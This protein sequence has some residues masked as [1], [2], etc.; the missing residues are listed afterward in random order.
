VI[1]CFLVNRVNIPKLLAH[2]FAAAQA[3]QEVMYIYSLLHK[4][5]RKTVYD[6]V[7]KPT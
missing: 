3:A 5:L 7:S 6:Q 1:S 2:H 4:Q